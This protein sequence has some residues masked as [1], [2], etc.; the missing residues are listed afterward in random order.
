MNKMLTIYVF[1]ILGALLTTCQ[2]AD[3]TLDHNGTFSPVVLKYATGF[4]LSTEG[5]IVKIQVI[6]PH[7]EA[8]E[9]FTYILY[10]RDTEKPDVEGDV[11]IQTPIESLVCTST[12]HIPLLD[13]LGVSNS[14]I[15]F[16]STNYISSEIM[17]NRVDQGL[18]TELGV[19]DQIN[20][21]AL[22]ALDPE[23]VMA[24]TMTND[25][26]QFNRMKDAEIDVVINAEYLEEHPLGRAEWIKFA[27]ALY[28]LSDKADSIFQ[29]IETNYMNT[30]LLA[31]GTA[32]RPSVLSG[33]VYGD[34]WYLPGGRNYAAKLFRDAQLNYIWEQDTSSGFMPL[35]FESVY[36]AARTARLWIGVGSFATL[37]EL[38]SSDQRYEQFDAFNNGLVYSFNKRM[39]AKGGSEYLELG[40]LRPDLILKDLVKIGHPN[41]LPE[42][43]SFFFF[44]LPE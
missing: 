10:P 4:T 18:I 33:I 21:E 20:M 44:R 38:R 3:T 5:N 35:S 12:T 34:S 27:G 32:N 15:G 17:R 42:Y 39:G 37:D 22:I 23:V 31:E 36:D 19:D 43:E 30:K 6:K 41:L 16:P 7:M 13:Y 8:T 29:A 28:N 26:G 9:G 25:Y 1:I 24:Y 40:Y 11:Y 14:L 2:S